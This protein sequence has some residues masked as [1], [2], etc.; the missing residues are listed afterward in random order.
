[1]LTDVRR[2][3]K[4]WLLV[5]VSLFLLFGGSAIGQEPENAGRYVKLGVSRFARGDFDHAI[6]YFE[7][8]LA[9]RPH[10]ASAYINRGKA[11]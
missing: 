6:E 2:S 7:R 8:A 5:A 9:S 3:H 10:L 4:R 1:M 11:H